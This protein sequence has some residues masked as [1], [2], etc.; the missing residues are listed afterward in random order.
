MVEILGSE[1]GGVGELGI[2]EGFSGVWRVRF[3]DVGKDFVVEGE[4]WWIWWI[5]FDDWDLMSVVRNEEIS[6]KEREGSV[7][8]F[9]GN[10]T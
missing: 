5:L 1:W 3:D 6:S 9:G 10:T 8:C 2:L 7:L 4:G